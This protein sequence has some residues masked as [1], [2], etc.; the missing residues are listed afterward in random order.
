MKSFFRYIRV[1]A[2]HLL[3]RFRP[4]L[5]LTE[6]TVI[7]APHPDDEVIGCAGLIQALVDRGMPPHVIILTGGEGSHRGCCD[8][9]AEEI[10][11]A[12]HQLTLKAAAT[13]G[14]PES[15]IHCLHYPDGGVTLEHPETE[16]LQTLLSE[17]NPQSVF[18]PHHGEGWSDHLQAAEITKHLLK[19]QDVSI[20]E[21]CVWMWYYNV[22][23]L[24]YRNARVLRM[25]CAQHQRKLQAM[26]EY[27]TP[28][29]SCG[30]PWSGVLPEPFLKAAR[31]NKELYFLVNV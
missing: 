6:K 12:R 5:S 24:D 15:H 3:Y 2:L 16:R 21:Y 9:S 4:A 18:I 27:V 25:S 14:L 20:Y 23:R 1:A 17:L 31:W 10:M 13:L 22:W 11:A 26:D 30:K 28:L 19:G 7:I 29:A 8:T